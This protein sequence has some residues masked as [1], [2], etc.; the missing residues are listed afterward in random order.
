V[1]RRSEAEIQA[2]AAKLH[3]LMEKLDDVDEKI[4]R[5]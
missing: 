4:R 1:N 2:L 3:L 5:R